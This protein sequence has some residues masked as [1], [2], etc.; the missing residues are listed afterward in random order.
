MT[1]VQLTFQLSR[2]LNDQDLDNISRVHGVY[3]FY[4]V[5]PRPTGD[6]LFV[7]Y[8]ASRLTPADVRQTLGEHGLPIV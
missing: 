6:E 8:D 2:A 1:K 3:G 7:E 5:R 4:A